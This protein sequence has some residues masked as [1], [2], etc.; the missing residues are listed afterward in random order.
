MT[1]TMD[2]ADLSLDFSSHMDSFMNITGD[3]GHFARDFNFDDIPDF[4]LTPEH[5]AGPSKTKK[6][7]TKKKIKK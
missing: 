5:A 1:P 2:G 6:S 7:P 3:A 4:N